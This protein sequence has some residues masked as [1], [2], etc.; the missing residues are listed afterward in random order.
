MLLAGDVGGTH[1]RLGRFRLGAGGRLEAAGE[2]ANYRSLDF[3]DLATA[4]VEFMAG[5][6][7]DAAC[8]GIP[9]PVRNNQATTPN[10][11]WPELDG[12]AI[13]AQLGLA[14][15]RALLMNDL[16]AA[17]AG[18]DDLGPHQ[19]MVLQEGESGAAGAHGNRALVSAGTGLGIALQT[20]TGDRWATLATEGGHM[21][22]SP[23][24]DEEWALLGYLSQRLAAESGGHVSAER[25]VSGPGLV[26]LYE[27]LRDRRGLAPHLK[28]EQA[29]ADKAAGVAN[30]DPSAAIAQVSAAED[31]PLCD[32][33]LAM[34]CSI[35]GAVAGNVALVGGATGGVFLGGGVAPKVRDR[36][37]EGEFLRSF[38]AKGRFAGYLS[39]IPVRIVL[40]PHA[41]LLGAAKLAA[42]AAGSNS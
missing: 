23:R 25:L 21:D 19:L 16:A 6:R 4:A 40:E 13:G 15:G 42:E 3:P 34:F 28:V 41:G 17:A 35:Y 12:D 27:F 30:A 29:L 26:N 11:P 1:I 8:F 33:T 38:R 37:V 24:D 31:S 7:L 22:F 9:G 39:R 36:L 5:E 32:R 14:A 18:L 2:M 10:L 20:R